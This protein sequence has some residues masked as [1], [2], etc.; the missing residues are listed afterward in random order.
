MRSS[1]GAA[2][3]A[4]RVTVVRGLLMAWE[5]FAHGAD[6]GVRGIGATPA[7]AF[8]QAALALTAVVTDPAGIAPRRPRSTIDCEAPDDELLLAD[9]LNA[10]IYEMATRKHA[11]RPLRGAH[12]R[13]AA[14][15]DRPGARRSTA[16]ATS[17]RSRSRA[18]PTRRCASRGAPTAHGWRNASSTCERG[19][20]NGSMDL[21]RLIRRVRVR[22]GDR[23]RTGAMRVPAIIYASEALI[24]DMDDKVSSRS[25]TS[26][27]CP[28]SSR[29]PTPCPTRTGATASRSAASRRSIPT[30]AA[31]CPRAA[32]ASTSPAA[33]AACTPASTPRTSGRA[34][35][36][37]PTR[38][39][40][41]FPRASAAPAR[42]ALDAAEMDAML[43]RRRALGGA[44]A[45]TARRRISS[46]SRSTGRWPAPS[47]PACRSRRRERQRDEM[48]TLGSGNHYLEVQRRGRDLR[49][50]DRR[51]ASACAAATSSSA[52]TAA[53][54]A[55]A[56]RS[57]PSSCS[58]MAIAR[59]ELR[60]R[61]A[62][63]RARLR[64]D[65]LRARPAL[66]RRDARGDQ[67]RARQPPDPHP[68]RR[69][70][71]SPTSC[72][73]RELDAALRR[74]AQHLQGR[75]ARGR[76][77]ARASSSC[78]ARARRAPSGP[79][80]PDL[81]EALRDVGQPVLI[82]GRWAPA[83]TC[84][85]APQEGEARAFSS[86]CHGA[87]RAHEPPPGA[88]SAGR[89]GRW[90]TS[91]PARGILIRSPSMRGVA[92][93]APGAYKDVGAVV[94]AADARRP[95]AQGGAARA[96]GLRQ[97]LAWP[98]NPLDPSTTGRSASPAA[99]VLSSAGRPSDRARRSARRSAAA[100]GRSAA[101]M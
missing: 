24:R 88:R 87:G 53:R 73:R 64:A 4:T 79:G 31:W 75:G 5:H 35:A 82:G 56:T 97:G 14:D 16:S 68:P 42:S 13:T 15:C 80:H 63:P 59:R 57:A 38:S 61:A 8:E 62:R 70:R 39:S 34:S 45:A 76:R 36:R 30:R 95:R 84:S 91:S 19:S 37:S 41:A 92:E 7:E 54:A 48:G 9:W 74:L 21:A 96:A 32:W 81:P 44:S 10:L 22:M 98:I 83:P 50:G 85:P 71:C 18:R 55:S 58:E 29:R 66:S 72:R 52:S 60:H 23:R 40:R 43:A 20:W 100:E 86:A 77:R 101:C 27:R 26:P 51:E 94:D 25:P 78:T 47:R 33:C 1:G 99:A 90:S 49:R 93:E 28:A 89:A 17:R 3:G 46:A 6:I 67:L 65:Q 11:L 2:S 69:A 12:R